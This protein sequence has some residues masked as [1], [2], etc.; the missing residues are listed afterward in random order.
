MK[1]VSTIF[2][3]VLAMSFLPP[4]MA[5]ARVDVK[6]L[7]APKPLYELKL[8]YM[9]A[10]GEAETSKNLLTVANG[11]IYVSQVQTDGTIKISDSIKTMA[12]KLLVTHVK[13]WTEVPLEGKGHTAK[14]LGPIMNTVLKKTGYELAGVFPFLIKGIFES[15]TIQSVSRK[16][17]SGLVVGFLTKTITADHAAP[18]FELAMHFIDDGGKYFGAVSDLNI[19]TELTSGLK[20]SLFMP[21]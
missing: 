12:S 7:G 18:T 15:I 11:R 8:K 14:S 3:I 10:I 20:T 19:A 2:L 13:H 1:R 9:Y 6:S 16:K 21:E 4:F 5:G 17:V